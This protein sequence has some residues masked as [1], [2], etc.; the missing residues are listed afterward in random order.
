M[1]TVYWMVMWFVARFIMMQ[2]EITGNNN[3]NSLQKFDL[4]FQSIIQCSDNT[5]RKYYWVINDSHILQQD[6]NCHSVLLDQILDIFSDP[7][8]S[9]SLAKSELKY[10]K[11]VKAAAWLF[12]HW[13]EWWCGVWWWWSVYASSVGELPQSHD[14]ADLC[15]LNAGMGSIMTTDYSGGRYHHTAKT[16][17]SYSLTFPMAPYQ[18]LSAVLGQS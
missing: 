3:C 2:M 11:S 6:Y 14:L 16:L 10:Q 15:F 4:H 12:D 8:S 9:H 13:C 17:S 18:S 1:C 5:M 7:L